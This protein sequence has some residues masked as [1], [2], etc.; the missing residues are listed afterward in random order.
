M[1]YSDFQLAVRNL[2]RDD[3]TESG[4]DEISITDLAQK[5]SELIEH[6]ILNQP[7]SRVVKV[8]FLHEIDECLKDFKFF[9]S[10]AKRELDRARK[11]GEGG[12][13]RRQR[14]AWQRVRDIISGVEGGVTTYFQMLEKYFPEEL[15]RYDS[16]TLVDFLPYYSEHRQVLT[17]IP[18]TAYEITKF[19]SKL[20]QFE[21]WEKNISVHVQDRAE[22]AEYWGV[23]EYLLIGSLTR[24]FS[25][26]GFAPKQVY[27]Q[28]I[29]AWII[30]SKVIKK[31]SYEFIETYALPA[32]VDPFEAKL[33]DY[34]ELG[35]GSVERLIKIE[36]AKCDE[37]DIDIPNGKNDLSLNSPYYNLTLYHKLYRK[38]LLARLERLNNPETKEAL[39]TTTKPQARVSTAEVATATSAARTQQQLTLKQ[40]AFAYNYQKI[41]I[42]NVEQANAIAQEFKHNSGEKLLKHFNNLSSPAD[43]TGAGTS[44]QNSRRKKDFE[45][46]IA[47]LTTLNIQAARW[48][49]EEYLIFKNNREKYS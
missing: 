13:T 34:L 15:G 36:I 9:I 27:E 10:H 5:E 37:W 14:Y 8:R 3:L 40:I 22:A 25:K 20:E 28:F 7:E 17:G 38:Y 33:N 31:V 42:G 46:V 12:S 18:A 32:L 21:Y 6:L 29:K 43:R 19:E 44:Q 45:A 35:T 48:A 4:L 24:G 39:P 47:Y 11:I 23:P 49:E 41:H 2:S 1:R 26:L 16:G 30:D